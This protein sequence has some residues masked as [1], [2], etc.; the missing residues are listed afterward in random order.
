MLPTRRVHLK[1]D[2]YLRENGVMC[3]E[4]RTA[5]VHSRMDRDL[6]KYGHWNRRYEEHKRLLRDVYSVQ[7]EVGKQEQ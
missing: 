3:E 5:T 2:E 6:Q 1:F 4:T 7:A